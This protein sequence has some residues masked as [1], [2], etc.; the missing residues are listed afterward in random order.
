MVQCFVVAVKKLRT[1]YI[2]N[3]QTIS[4]SDNRGAFSYYLPIA[5]ATIYYYSETELT[6]G[7]DW[8]FVDGVP[9]AW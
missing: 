5:S 8:H 1:D 9:T 3:R 6:A 7:N 4:P 2:K